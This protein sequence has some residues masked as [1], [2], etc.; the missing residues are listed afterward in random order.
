M[1][2]HVTGGLICGLAG[3]LLAAS[4]SWGAQQQQQQPQ[5]QKP[6]SKQEK[7]QQQTTVENQFGWSVD[8]GAERSDN[9]A[10]T[11]TDELSETTGILGLGINLISERPRLSTNVSADLEY[12]DYLDREFESEISGGLD[13]RV[14]AYFIPERF[15]WV[16]ED[17]YGQIA[18]NRQVADTP[19]NR[20]QINYLSTGPE[21]SIP[22]GA[23]TDLL[24][25]ARWT[26]TY[27]EESLEDNNATIANVSLVRQFTDVA[28][29]SLDTSASKTEF[30]EDQL[31]PE[32]ETRQASFGYQLRAPKTTLLADVGYMKYEQ[33]G[34]APIEEEFVMARVDFSRLITRRTT[35]RI[36]G[37]TRPSSTGENFRRDQSIIGIGD[38]AEAA[39]AAADIFRADDAYVSWSTVYD[40]SSVEFVVS[41][42]REKH[43]VIVSLDRE[44]LRG[45]VT[46]ERRVTPN[47]TVDLSGGYLQEERTQTGFQFDEWFAGI[48]LEWQLSERFSLNSRV[49]HSVGSSDDGSRDYTENRAYIGIR[50]SGGQQN[51]GR[52]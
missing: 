31:F 6:Q 44:Q 13:G 17:N 14:A 23:R 24:L 35:L 33:K 37:G 22:L 43:E 38:G 27:L 21:L 19:G 25:G 10:R 48:E 52:N 42:R 29:I 12:R 7:P 32:Y 30:D 18:L 15:Y 45:L 5:A 49:Y 4:P 8:V 20:Q 50:Y 36:A 26:D 40:R 34:L 3:L 9:I 47:T 2:V 46:Y 16:V 41:G 28:S 1:R 11:D 39:Q 51:V